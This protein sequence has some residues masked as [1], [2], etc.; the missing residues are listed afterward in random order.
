MS[1]LKLVFVN[2]IGK[3]S[4]DIYEYEFFFSET[5]D[6]VWGEDWYIQCP[7]ACEN[8]LPVETSYSLIKH[9]KTEIKL[10][11]AQENTCF[12]LQDCIDGCLAI[13]FQDINGLEEYPT[14]YRLVLHFG[15]DYDDVI[16]KLSGMGLSFEEDE[17]DQ[18]DADFDG[19]DDAE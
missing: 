1:L 16:A 11:C 8:I 9:L 6:V 3:S 7:A 19:F 10:F 13:C 15:E 5:P 4:D 17:T 18:N 14:P 12:S 2:P